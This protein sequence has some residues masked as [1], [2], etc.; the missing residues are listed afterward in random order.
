M[1][2]QAPRLRIVFDTNVLLSLWVFADSRY[3][4][5]RGLMETGSLIALCNQ[6][7]LAEFERVLNYPEFELTIESQRVM[8]SEYGDLV[9]MIAK[10][11]PKLEFPLPRCRDED[12]QKFLELA[13][14]GAADYL[15]TGDKA[16][17]ALARHKK[18]PAHIAILTPDAF[19]CRSGFSPS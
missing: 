12:D 9:S 19:L 5:L 10:P 11:A 14:D 13:R 2:S 15:L 18:L 16:L 7:C 8:L 17:L 1:I 4:P 6:D 3:A